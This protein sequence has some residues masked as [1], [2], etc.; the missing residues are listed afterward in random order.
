LN[1]VLATLGSYGDVHPFVGIG[2]RLKRR[3]HRVTLLSNGAFESLARAEGL[4][5]DAFAH[6]DD[7]E[8]LKQDP[9]LWHKTRAFK[10][11][12]GAVCDSLGDVYDAVE[13]NL[14][15]NTIVVSSSLALGARV[16]QDALKF[17]MATAHLSP[18]IFRSNY[19]PAKLPGLFMPRWL[20]P[21]VKQKLWDLG[22]SLVIDPTV[23]PK[24]N[25]FRASKGLPP[26]KRVL[27][28]WW[29]SPD[30]VIGM[31]PAWFAPPQPDWP[32]QTRLTGF[33]LYDERGVQALPEE[34][35]E[36]L[37]NG[38][39][40]IAFTP[41]SAMLHA[42]DFFQSAIEACERLGRRGILLTRHPEQ[43]PARLPDSVIHVNFAPFSELLPRVAA[44]VHHGGIGTSSQALAAGV[45]QLVTP[46]THD[47]PDNANRLKRLGVAEVVPFTRF[48]ARRATAA[49]RRLFADP[50]R[51]ERCRE[52]QSRFVGVD[53]LEQTCDF[54][55]QLARVRAVTPQTLTT[56]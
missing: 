29:H 13:R 45:P 30:R 24:L 35:Q 32:A 53:A 33:P 39:P 27:R 46:M 47:Q 49:M 42:A 28:D 3:G 19:E 52:V 16:A 26:V 15:D 22:D 2:A 7:Y 36:F 51:A 18:G 12:F 4:E 20:P 44:M 9:D 38:Q 10:V 40:P 11:V 41:G 8:R 55:E 43:I 23:A 37:S 25:E 54:V 34:L 6:G 31:F 17:P 14:T 5:F 48:T 56:A 1:I 50:Q 21:G